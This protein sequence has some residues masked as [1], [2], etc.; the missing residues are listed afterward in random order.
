MLLNTII[1]KIQLLFNP[2][3][4][5]S[6]ILQNIDL[7]IGL[8]IFCV[9]FLSLFAQSDNIGYFALF[10]IIMATIPQTI[11]IRFNPKK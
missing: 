4:K 5:K 2:I 1:N 7:L 3:Y 6:Y 8:N 11:M 10:A 9:I